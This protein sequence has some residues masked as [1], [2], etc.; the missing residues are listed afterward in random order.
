[1]SLHDRIENSPEP[2][3]PGRPPMGLPHAPGPDHRNS[4]LYALLATAREPMAVLDR[5]FRVLVASRA[6][7]RLFPT[8]FTA[9]LGQPFCDPGASNWSAAALQTL[10]D[11]VAR[12]AVAEDVEIELDVPGAGPRRMLLNARQTSDRDSPDAAVLVALY[13]VT[14]L[15]DAERLKAEIAVQE[16]MLLQEAHH[17]IANSLQIIASILLLKARSVKSEETRLH[18]R[19]VHKRLIL[20]AEVQRQLCSAGMLDEIEFGPYVAR[21]CAGLADSMTDGDDRVEIVTTSTDGTIKSDDAI[22]FGLIVTELVINALKHGYPDGRQGCIEVDFAA[23]G[24]NWR[25]T[26]SDDGVGRPADG[27][28]SHTGLGT[29]I[30]EALARHLKARVEIAQ[31]DIGSSTSIVHSE[32]GNA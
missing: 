27:E 1:M 26:V 7:H 8:K 5:G 14:E 10:K 15:R 21:L 23:D 6:Y 13:D 2:R 3:D 9:L 18:L 4:A 32:P 28:Q 12:D 17:R 11:V 19:D 30:V 22:S 16:A 31:N 20:V 29:N 24:P 25:L